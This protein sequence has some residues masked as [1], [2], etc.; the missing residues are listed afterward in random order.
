LPDFRWATVHLYPR[1]DETFTGR[2][3]QFSDLA[4]ALRRAA[5]G[6]RWAFVENAGE[7]CYNFDAIRL[8]FKPETWR[9]TRAG[10]TFELWG[11]VVKSQEAGLSRHPIQRHRT[12]RKPN[13]VEKLGSH[14]IPTPYSPVHRK[15]S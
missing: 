6:L 12:T 5:Q 9:V 14:I 7:K 13:L 11:G 10:H 2:R 1:E 3:Y 8:P 15:A 4:D